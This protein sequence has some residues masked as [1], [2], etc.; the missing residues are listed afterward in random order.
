MKKNLF[1]I[2]FLFFFFFS[3]SVFALV[4]LEPYCRDGYYK[5][6][7][8]DICSRAPNC[9]GKG[10]DEVANLPA[11]NPQACM[12][13]DA[14]RKQKGCAGYVP[15][16]CYQMA[17]KGNF[18]YCVGYWERLWCSPDLCEK[19]RQNG[20]SD[21]NC[22]GSCNCGHAFKSWCGPGKT[23][24]PIEQRL[25]IQPTPTLTL[26]P[27][28]TPTPTPTNILFPTTFP[29]A[30][31]TNIP[32]P[33]KVYFPTPTPY[34]RENPSKPTSF[35]LPQNEQPTPT[36]EVFSPSPF[37]INFPKLALPRLKINKEKTEKEVGKILDIFPQ[38]FYQIK[39]VDERIELT[40]NNFLV[41]FSKKIFPKDY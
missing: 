21:K 7:N 4:D 39:N 36:V 33:T 19:A 16:C 25:G 30:T 27:S 13:T 6:P 5:I 38:I 10:Y 35:S 1:L 11:P 17:L 34:F 31:P 28:S 15:L 20:A 9:G 2:L 37:L 18:T 29:T 40:I 26:T 14:T 22:G 8:E 23:S 41:I 12:G 24:I 32:T 3:F